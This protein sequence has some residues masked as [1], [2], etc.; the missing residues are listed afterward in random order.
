MAQVDRLRE[1][2]KK[3]FG[4]GGVGVLQVR[5]TG[6]LWRTPL[7]E[8]NMFKILGGR[9]SNRN[10]ELCFS[11]EKVSSGKIYSESYYVYVNLKCRLALFRTRPNIYLSI[12]CRFQF[13][14][15]PLKGSF[16]LLYDFLGFWNFHVPSCIFYFSCMFD[17]VW[18]YLRR[19]V[20]VFSIYKLGFT[21]TQTSPI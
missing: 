5:V 10:V 11:P 1:V 3:R 2:A 14:T 6:N 8:L 18:L 4:G 12:D 19:I 7:V 15:S 16:S 21:C 13:L 20:H 9:K 17:V